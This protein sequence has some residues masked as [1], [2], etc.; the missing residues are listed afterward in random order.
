MYVC[1]LLNSTSSKA[2]SGD[3]PIQVL[4]GSN[5]DISPLLQF[6][7]Y[8]PVYYLVDDSPF[9]SDSRGKCGYFVG[10]TEHVGHAM[11]FKV[12]TNDT[13]KI[14]YHLNIQLADDSKTH[15]LH[16]DPLNDD[17]TSPIIRSHH[18]SSHHGE[19]NVPSNMPIINPHDLVGRT[20]LLPQQKDH[21]QCFC[22]RIVKALDD[23]ESDLG[24]QP[25]CIHFLCSAK[26]GK[27]EEIL[28]DSVSCQSRVTW[29]R[30]Y[31]PNAS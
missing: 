26:D 29:I 20:F 30:G 16:L 25:D 22:A 21:C 19:G 27:F 9:P 17:I 10:I 6:C 14:I 8:E 23:Y 4:M 12:L 1:F 5:K 18:N 7:W 2:L 24:T 13:Q 3:V 31:F 11:T 28:S 15:N